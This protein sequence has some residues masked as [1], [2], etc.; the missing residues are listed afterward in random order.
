MLG[1]RFSKK[2]GTYYIVRSLEILELTPK[3]RNKYLS[4]WVRV[5]ED[6]VVE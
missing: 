3:S 5:A 6:I 1:V 4:S 2:F